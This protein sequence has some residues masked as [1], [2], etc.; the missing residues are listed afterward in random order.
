M[1]EI[2]RMPKWV[3]DTDFL[4]YSSNISKFIESYNIQDICEIDLNFLRDYFKKD[5]FVALDLIDELGMRGFEFIS[6]MKNSILPQRIDDISVE[7]ILAK[8]FNEKYKQL[9][10][11]EINCGNI[12]KRFKISNDKFFDYVPIMGFKHLNKNI[13]IE[14][15][16]SIFEAQEFMIFSN[17]LKENIIVRE[18]DIENT[19][20][21]RIVEY[22]HETTYG[23]FR[24]Y[25]DENGIKFIDELNEFNF[26]ILI[27]Y[28]GFGENRISKIKEKYNL[29]FK[30]HEI[31]SKKQQIEVVEETEYLA[32]IIHND[33]QGMDI[34]FLLDEND[35]VE[36]IIINVSKKYSLSKMGELAKLPIKEIAQ[37]KGIGLNKIE[38]IKNTILKYRD[39]IETFLKNEFQ[40]IKNMKNYG[41]YREKAINRKKTLEEIGQENNIT[42]ERVRQI[43]IKVESRIKKLLYVIENYIIDF[44][45]KKAI[46]K[47]EDLKT[48]FNSY[49]DVMVIKYCMENVEMSRIAYFKEIDKF[50]IDRNKDEI[51]TILDNTLEKLPDIFNLFDKLDLIINLLLEEN[52]EFIDIED[53]EAYMIAKGYKKK[54][55]FYSK[56]GFSLSN[57][58]NYILEYYFIDGIR[59]DKEGIESI[60]NI[61]KKDFGI[62]DLP[63]D[64]AISARIETDNILR[65]K[66]TYIHL[67]NIKIQYE[68]FDEIKNF[69]DCELT[70][71]KSIPMGYLFELFKTKLYRDTSID[72]KYYLYGILKFI[73]DNEFSFKRDFVLKLES[74]GISTHEIL[75][76]HVL[77]SGIKTK[78]EII[79]E[80]NWSD[81]TLNQAVSMNSKLLLWKNGGNIIHV[82]KLNCDENLLKTVQE[83]L[84]KNM[85]EGYTNSKI[86]FEKEKILFLK[87]GIEDEFSLFS[88]IETFLKDNFS[89][90]RPH[91]LR[92]KSVKN[93]TTVDL[94]LKIIQGKEKFSY[95]WLEKELKKLMIGEVMTR[96]SFDKIKE[97]FLQI[98]YDEFIIKEKIN[99][100]L[101]WIEDVNNK[102][103]SSFEKAEY[104]PLTEYS[105][106]GFPPFEDKDLYWNEFLLEALIEAYFIHDYKL[107]KSQN[108]WRFEK[109]IVVRNTSALNNISDLIKYILKN[110]YT[111]LE[112]MIVDKIEKYLKD[113]G[114]I[115]K[116]LPQ[117]I[118]D[119]GI[120]EVDEFGRIKLKD[121]WS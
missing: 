25:C 44:N 100:D 52:I 96:I 43:L 55:D 19:K 9:N 54:N 10:F 62:L 7:Y 53:F 68:L 64:R 71:K 65:N 121:G 73:F 46:L 79:E 45:E 76:K 92:E 105:F 108:D 56:K 116:S 17:E 61:A 113:K 103:K 117:E 27:D 2:I 91:I 40:E 48:I 99:F 6:S 11:S 95:K 3:K 98:S 66:H 30:K 18:K 94:I 69:L 13:N 39:G 16:K 83:L 32:D 21:V 36:K 89:F 110:E 35:S 12:I 112:N 75:E 85:V 97:G 115:H 119:S 51:Q 28:K 59:L 67:N 87:Y 5:R 34:S 82:S 4:K 57:L 74:R 26:D 84:E 120:L 42:R 88:F 49:E 8:G 90:R 14:Y 37:E 114:V 50:V 109:I 24:N 104:I 31:E 72:N 107:I 86:I 15:I 80:L 63:D 58:Y 22:F 38:E 41:Y 47:S 106:Y 77:E 60:R 111:D 101:E 78:K 118:F 33:F 81:Y 70:S 102:F 93:F 29:L 1:D 20:K 23:L